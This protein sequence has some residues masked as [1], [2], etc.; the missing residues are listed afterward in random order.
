MR[1]GNLDKY[2]VLFNGIGHVLKCCT[3]PNLISK[4]SNFTGKETKEK[5]QVDSSQSNKSF[6]RLVFQLFDISTRRAAYLG[7]II[8]SNELPIIIFAKE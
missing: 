5:S 8:L 4:T 6:P 7:S 1:Y 3:G 2:P